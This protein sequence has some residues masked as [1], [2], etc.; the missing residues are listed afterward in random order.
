MI[1]K[2]R[3]KIIN[4]TDINPA[5]LTQNMP[6]WSIK[7]H[8]FLDE[9]TLNALQR[10]QDDFEAIRSGLLKVDVD[11]LRSIDEN[12]LECGEDIIFIATDNGRR[13]YLKPIIVYPTEA[14]Y[15]CLG[16][17]VIQFYLAKKYNLSLL[18]YEVSTNNISKGSDYRDDTIYVHIPSSSINKNIA[19][20]DYSLVEMYAFEILDEY[21]IRGEKYCPNYK[22]GYAD[23]AMDELH[24]AHALADAVEPDLYMCD[25]GFNMDDIKY[26]F[27]F[28]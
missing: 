21:R 22:V 7:N 26:Q 24:M 10:K 5:Y 6:G 4:S 17:D 1:E 28:E 23:P 15:N 8:D 2:N 18:V 11:A 25:K 3:I 12:D 20:I 16:G 27:V 14:G 9:G 19:D 13:V